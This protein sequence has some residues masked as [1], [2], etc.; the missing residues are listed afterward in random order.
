MLTAMGVVS[1][2]RFIVTQMANVT[3]ETSLTRSPIVTGHVRATT[4]DARLI[5]FATLGRLFAL[6]ILAMIVQTRAAATTD[7][8]GC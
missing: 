6:D 1:W 2:R 4:V 5:H 7:A 3:F 8:V